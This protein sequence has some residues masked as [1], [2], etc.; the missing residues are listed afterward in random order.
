MTDRRHFLG[1]LGAG[2]AAL[3]LGR[4]A[5][6]TTIRGLTLEELSNESERILLG[7]A[8]ESSSHWATIGG[9]RRIVTE[10]RWRVDDAIAK[11]A[12]SDAEVMIRTL[13]GRV[14]DVGAIVHG[15]AEIA[16]EQQC[17]L[18]LNHL[19]D[20]ALR[21][22]GMAQG[23]Y[24]LR[25][26]AERIARLRPSPRSGE[27]LAHERGAIR[28]LVNQKLPDARVMIRGAIRK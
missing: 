2:L 25:L 16:L 4:T 23:H 27:V 3:S 21:V 10:T 17:V 15:E 5:Q 1:V 8:L 7:T 18:F 9:R 6:A 19:P 26:D 20:G 28:R 12:P 13:G 24:P 11:S 22:T 14:G